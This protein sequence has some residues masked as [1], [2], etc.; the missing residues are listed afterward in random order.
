MWGRRGIRV[1]ASVAILALLGYAAA[2]AYVWNELTGVSG[3]CP[4]SW[5]T[6]DPT[7]FEVEHRPTFDTTP[8]AMP[9]PQD[10][11]FA[12]R[13]PRVEVS[14]WWIPAAD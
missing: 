7:V 1:A 10:V 11:R 13:D 6:N 9:A 5:P 3:D 14:G 2:S 8:H 4:R 12:G